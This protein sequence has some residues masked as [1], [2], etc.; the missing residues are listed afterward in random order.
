[1]LMVA[2]DQMIDVWAIAADAL[3]CDFDGFQMQNFPN[4]NYLI[5]FLEDEFTISSR[6]GK[7]L[8]F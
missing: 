1:M 5:S 7:L 3:A 2:C 6:Q 8:G 4:I